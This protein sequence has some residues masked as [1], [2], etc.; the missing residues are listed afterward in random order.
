MKKV[1]FE[2][3]LTEVDSAYIAESA[4]PAE[5]KKRS[6]I[7]KVIP[8]AVIAACFVLTANAVAPVDLR[9]YLSAAFGDGYEVIGEM[10][11]MPAHVAYRSSGDEISLELK[12]IVGDG[13]VVKVFVDLTISADTEIPEGL[14][15]TA[16]FAL[17]DLSNH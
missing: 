14:G 6:I 17:F 13:H 16:E 4:E 1:N 11:S 3:A 7:W 12:G 2:N 9:F 5:K 10:V 8:A 15:K